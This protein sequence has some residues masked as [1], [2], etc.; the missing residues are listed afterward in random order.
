[1][2]MSDSQQALLKHWSEYLLEKG[3]LP[4]RNHFSLK[5][6]GRHV[7]NIVIVDVKADPL[8]F[9]Y[10]L[11]GTSVAEFMYEDYTGSRLSGIPGKGRNSKVWSFLQKT[12][13]DGTPHYF[14]VPYIGP[15]EGRESV[16]TL[17]LPLASDHHNTD[18]LLL[19]P[20]YDIKTAIIHVGL[21]TLH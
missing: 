17:Y 7:A 4:S 3:S 19:V 15:R 13:E 21:Q 6:L 20:H 1:M 12:Y 14:Q 16:Y 8:D 9:E 18:K 11:V 5:D 10:R 2:Q